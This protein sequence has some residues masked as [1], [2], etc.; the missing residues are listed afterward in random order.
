MNQ[1]DAWCHGTGAGI[2]QPRSMFKKRPV[3]CGPS[4]PGRTDRLMPPDDEIRHSLD[5]T[6]LVCEMTL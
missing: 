2:T 1:I 5:Q 6:T 3:S 4:L